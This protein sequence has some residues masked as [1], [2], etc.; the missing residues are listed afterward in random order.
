MKLFKTNKK[1]DEGHRLVLKNRQSELSTKLFCQWRWV[2]TGTPT[3]NLT[4]SVTVKTKS[5]KD[6]LTR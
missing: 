4:E 2:C 1:I 6:D 5:E 3:Q